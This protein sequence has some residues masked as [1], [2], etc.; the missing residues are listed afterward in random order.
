MVKPSRRRTNHRPRNLILP[1]LEQSKSSVLNTLGSL[2]SRRS[3]CASR[4]PQAMPASTSMLAG[5]APKQPGIGKPTVREDQFAD[6][7]WEGLSSGLGR[8][9]ALALRGATSD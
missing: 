6:C 5:Y 9:P 1:E 7:L 8:A 4:N 2:Q 3:E